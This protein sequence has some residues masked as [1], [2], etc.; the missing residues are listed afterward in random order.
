M[1]VLQIEQCAHRLNEAMIAQRTLP[2]L[3][4]QYP[5]L[6]I[7]QAYALSLIHI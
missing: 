1:K 3:T 4:T 6:T 2:P 7:D 5:D